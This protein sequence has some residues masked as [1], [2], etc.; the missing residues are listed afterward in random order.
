MKLKPTNRMTLNTLI[1]YD[2]LTLLGNEV[3]N[4]LRTNPIRHQG[5][6]FLD[7]FIIQNDTGTSQN[8]K[9]LQGSV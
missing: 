1:R 8:I 7:I 2:A 9:M 4:N 6:V 3:S 5:D